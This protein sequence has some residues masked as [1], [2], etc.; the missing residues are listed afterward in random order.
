MIGTDLA[1]TLLVA[2]DCS[3]WSEKAEVERRRE[4]PPIQPKTILLYKGLALLGTT[5]TTNNTIATIPISLV[6]S[7]YLG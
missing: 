7:C 1:I 5:T 4:E 2:F 6:G 3:S